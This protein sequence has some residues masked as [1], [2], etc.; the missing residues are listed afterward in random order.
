MRRKADVRLD[1]RAGAVKAEKE[2]QRGRET[3]RKRERKIRLERE[4]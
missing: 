4:S 1:G 2:R 3:Q